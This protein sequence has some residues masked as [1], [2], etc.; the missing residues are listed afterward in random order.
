VAV[1]HL[2]GLSYGLRRNPITIVGLAMLGALVAVALL[3]P[4]LAPHDPYATNPAVSLRPPGPGHLFGTDTFGHDI[5][6]R[7]LYGARIDLIV[8]AGAVGVAM[9]LGGLLGAVAGYAGG[10]PDDGIMRV[11]DMLQAF[12]NFILA[13]GIAAALGPSLTN[14]IIAIGL[15]NLPIYARLVRSRLL[16]LRVSGF[17][18]AAVS[19]GNPPWRVLLIHLLPNS[20][21]PIFIQAT[22]QSG[23]AILQ[24]AG[25]SFIGLGVRVPT[26]EWGVMISMGVQQLTSGHWWVSFFPGLAIM[27]AV[28]SFNLLGDGLQDLLDPRRR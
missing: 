5:F 27:F 3:A 23:W 16:T 6:S 24:A 10:W 13:L 22:L 7:V 19:V 21:A 2:A 9:V 26:P 4:V 20:L 17:A 12:P 1:G 28:I 8:A 14:L 11:M 15:T 18:L 25:L